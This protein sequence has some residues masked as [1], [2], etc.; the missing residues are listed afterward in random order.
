MDNATLLEFTQKV[1]R[2]TDAMLM[3]N[4]K[5]GIFTNHE[6]NELFILNQQ[7]KGLVDFLTSYVRN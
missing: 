2:L 1:F 5:E 3:A 6:H 7:A 4:N